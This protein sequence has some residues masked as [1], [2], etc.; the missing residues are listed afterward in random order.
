LIVSI[1]KNR[2]VSVAVCLS[3]QRQSVLTTRKVLGTLAHVLDLQI[4]GDRLAVNHA[5]NVKVIGTRDEKTKRV[6]VSSKDAIRGL[7][8]AAS[9]INRTRIMFAAFTGARA[10]EQWAVRWLH[11]DFVTREL[12][13]ESRVDAWG[14][15]DVTKSEAG[16]RTIPLGG[17]LVS[18]LRAWKL[19]SPHSKD[20]DL[21]FPNTEGGHV[22]HTNFLKRE[23]HPLF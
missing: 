14:D 11:V 21:I 2:H 18:E 8:E 19:R 10:G 12:L 23:W 9:S 1:K 13:V 22:H 16:M 7:L 3:R 17:A 6:S 4:A 20:D 15:E 5:R